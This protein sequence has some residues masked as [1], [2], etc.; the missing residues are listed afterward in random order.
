[1]DIGKWESEFIEA[2]QQLL[3]SS[4]FYRLSSRG[5]D[6]IDGVV[7]TSVS[8]VPFEMSLKCVRCGIAFWFDNVSWSTG[9]ISTWQISS[10]SREA[11]GR[12]CGAQE[13]RVH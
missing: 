1:M 9:G 4:D 13:L 2:R 6:L 5:H 10:I 11:A 12:T 7:L 8:D 3:E